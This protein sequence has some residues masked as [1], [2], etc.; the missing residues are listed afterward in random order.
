MHRFKPIPVC[1]KAPNFLLLPTPHHSLSKT[2]S[3]TLS[4]YFTVIFFLH[5]LLCSCLEDLSA[6]HLP[7]SPPKYPH[8]LPYISVSFQVLI[9]LPFQFSKANKYKRILV[10]VQE[11]PG[12]ATTPLGLHD[13]SSCTLQAPSRCPNQLVLP[14]TTDREAALKLMHRHGPDGPH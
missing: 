1:S 13:H 7:S 9:P 2:P 8:Q 14:G 3:L 6:I 10:T 12:M 4:T 11:S 5:L